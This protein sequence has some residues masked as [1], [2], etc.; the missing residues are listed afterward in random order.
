MDAA[1]AQMIDLRLGAHALILGNQRAELHLG[2]GVVAV[3]KERLIA[4][5]LACPGLYVHA[6]QR[7][8]AARVQ[9]HRRIGRE[10]DRPLEHLADLLVGKQLVDRAVHEHRAARFV[11][12]VHRQAEPLQHAH[13]PAVAVAH[14]GR[15]GEAVA[16]PARERHAA[17][18]PLERRIERGERLVKAAVLR[19][20]F[21][22]GLSAVRLEG[23]QAR[24]PVLRAARALEDRA[25]QMRV[26]ELRAGAVAVLRT[27]VALVEQHVG[28]PLQH[29]RLSRG[30]EHT[31]AQRAR[32]GRGIHAV[33]Q[34]HDDRI[35]LAGQY[36][37]DLAGKFRRRA[38]GAERAGQLRVHA[39]DALAHGPGRADQRV[40]LRFNENLRIA[41]ILLARALRMAVQL[42]A[43]HVRARA[44][45]EL[46]HVQRAGAAVA[47]AAVHQAEIV[48]HHDGRGSV[49]SQRAH[50][51]AEMAAE[52]LVIGADDIA[53]HAVRQAD[54]SLEAEHSVQRIAV[55]DAGLH[56]YAALVAGFGQAVADFVEC[57]AV[58][59]CLVDGRVV[60][61]HQRHHHERAGGHAA[62]VLL[63]NVAAGFLNVL[64][65]QRHNR[66]QIHRQISSV[67]PAVLHAA[68]R[69]RSL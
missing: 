27:G 34:A 8:E 47:G 36:P 5:A 35:A 11:R 62:S 69:S 46:G 18:Q 31:G 24:D 54:I 25:G 48:V 12:E 39:V 16:R 51:R 53:L 6:G 22:I 23:V 58:N 38:A 15:R 57:L 37:R 19:Q 50:H 21:A 49:R 26:D 67:S 1:V 40:A 10:E 30:I 20:L 7:A 29:S 66:I 44:A 17:A 33:V 28:L 14:G 3:H 55:T 65:V 52:A 42:L 41:A 60:L 4:G 56:Q 45:V 61:G 43:R 63:A 9:A 32:A 64:R 2:V 68:G 59:A 13:R